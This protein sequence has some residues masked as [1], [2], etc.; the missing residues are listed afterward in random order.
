MTCAH[1]ARTDEGCA[2]KELDGTS[3]RSRAGDSCGKGDS[4]SRS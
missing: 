4:L 2:V 1:G 3:R